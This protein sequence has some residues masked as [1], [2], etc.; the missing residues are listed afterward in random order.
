MESSSLSVIVIIPAYN[1][2][3]SIVSVIQEI[4]SLVREIIVVN[5]CST[6]KTA[7]VSEKAGA[8][9]LTENR[10]GYGYA[11]LKGI[12]YTAQKKN[13]PTSWFFLMEIIPI[14]PMSY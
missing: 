3:K 14:I 12:E 2:E 10:M 6:D 4:P 13:S 5:N 7:A 1:E 9:V 8:T 11:C